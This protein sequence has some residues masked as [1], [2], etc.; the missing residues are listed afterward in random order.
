MAYGSVRELEYQ[1][2]LAWRLS[3][4]PKPNYEQL[5]GL[6]RETGKVL[7]GLIRSFRQRGSSTSK[8]TG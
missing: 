2:S 1:L 4:L 3:Y 8:P 5:S 7:S 6:C